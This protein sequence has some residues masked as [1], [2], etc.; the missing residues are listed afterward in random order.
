ML[1]LLE[2]EVKDDERLAVEQHVGSEVAHLGE[3]SGRELPGDAVSLLLGNIPG[4][5]FNGGRPLCFLEP[6]DEA[7]SRERPTRKQSRRNVRDQ[8]GG[9][10]AGCGL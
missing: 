9:S 2:V 5:A 4:C 6:A 1:A 8:N 7:G 3:G 10:D